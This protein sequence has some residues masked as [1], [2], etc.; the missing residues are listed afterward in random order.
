[1]FIYPLTLALIL[2]FMGIFSLPRRVSWEY[3]YF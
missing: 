2:F 3:L 1:L